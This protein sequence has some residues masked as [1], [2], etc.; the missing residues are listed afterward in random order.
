MAVIKAGVPHLIKV[1]TKADKMGYEAGFKLHYFN[2][3]TG[4][5]TIVDD[6]FEEL[7]VTVDDVTTKISG[8]HSAGAKVIAVESVDG[9]SVGS[10]AK[11]GGVYYRVH[12]VDSDNNKLTLK[13]GLE[14]A[15]V[16]GDEVKLSGRTGTYGCYVTFP[17]P[18]SY[19]VHIT[20]FSLGMDNVPA[21]VMVYEATVDD[22]DNLLKDVKT[23]VDSIKTQVDTLDEDKLNSV[24]DSFGSLVNT[25]ENIRD[26]VTDVT[27]TVVITGDQTDNL[28]NGD[29]V[30]GKDSG[31]LGNV[32]SATYNS[33]DDETTV[34]LDNVKGTFD[35]DNTELLRNDTTDTDLDKVKS[36]TYGG[37]AV[38]SVLEFVKTLNEELEN[39][40][41]GLEAITTIGKDIKHLVNGDDTLEDGSDNPTA[42]KGLVQIFDELAS[43]HDDVAA[44]KD[45]AEDATNGFKA[46]RDAVDDAKSSIE[47][48]IAALIDEDDE[49]SL[50]S[51]IN[52][53]KSVVD[54]N[55]GLLE[56]DNYGLSKIMDAAN[57]LLDLFKDGGDIEVRF[58]DI[59]DALSDLNTKI[60]NSMSHIDD[61]F[62]DVM[63]AINGY[64][65]QTRFTVFA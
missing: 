4:E 10:T 5:A 60:D 33:D 18:G 55:K 31:A 65:D 22:V 14:G 17:E 44:I 9:F 37:G 26:L 42:G 11:I 13:R 32:L 3:A 43:T 52:A 50:A 28:D 20:N 56:D 45:L 57:N 21:P 1:N 6:S 2:D 12:G 27:A 58:D 47:G 59:D 15:V 38:D 24:A 51:K 29:I 49:D 16:D 41:T 39:G 61:R 63:D 62:D 54:A 34:S 30:K 40:A 36:V 23:E 46:I 7:Q 25:I 53:V 48:K 19:T 64:A 35:V 8:D